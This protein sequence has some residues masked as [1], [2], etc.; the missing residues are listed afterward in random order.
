MD[1][2]KYEQL[3]HDATVVFCKKN[4]YWFY[5]SH[6]DEEQA[7]L[8]KNGISTNQFIHNDYKGLEIQDVFPMVKVKSRQDTS[9][10]NL[11]TLFHEIFP[12]EVSDFSTFNLPSIEYLEKL[13][14]SL[15]TL[16][17]YKELIKRATISFC[18]SNN[19]GI[20]LSGYD[21]DLVQKEW[22]DKDEIN[23]MFYGYAHTDF[24]ELFSIS[25]FFDMTDGDWSHDDYHHI[26]SAKYIDEKFNDLE[27]ARR[28]HSLNEALKTQEG[29]ATRIK[30]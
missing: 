19:V 14:V 18:H 4:G 13:S 28:F 23:P 1:L 26:A 17:Q 22:R 27:P 20:N 16:D 2:Q 6:T 29:K 15:E 3:L 12:E 8:V 5:G 24:D 7:I 11:F 25:V 21:I 9:V 10:L 30:V